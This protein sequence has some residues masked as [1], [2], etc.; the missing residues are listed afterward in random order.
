MPARR[1]RGRQ[2]DADQDLL[3][4]LPAERGPLSGRGE[5]GPFQLAARC[6]RRRHR[7]GL[8]GSG[9]DP[10]DEHLPQLFPRAR[11]RRKAGDRSAASTVE[12]AERITRDE[13][14]KMGIQ[15]RDTGAGGRHPLRRR[16]AIGGHRARGLLRRQGAD[17]RRADGRAGRQGSRRRAALHRAGAGAR[18][19]R[20]L[21]HPQRPS[22]LPDR[23]PLHPPQPGPLLRHLRQ[24]RDQPRR[25][26]AD[27]GRR[28][29]AGG[30]RP[31]AGGVR[32][33]RRRKPPR[34]RWPRKP[35]RSSSRWD[36]SSRPKGA[37]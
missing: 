5:R 1:Q 3:R 20:G 10:A 24:E 19:R 33:A 30:A 22:R 17:P 21:H 29:G 23:R 8:P 27:D 36:A 35:T 34:R 15:V 28:R 32:P 13:L 12:A 26:R 37:R 18:P 14:H 7:H 6:A 2:I 4:R 31:R 25:G 9:D 16:A 11:S